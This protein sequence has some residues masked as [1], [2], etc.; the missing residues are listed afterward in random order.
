MPDKSD[1]AIDLLR[2]MTFILIPD[3][4]QTA[5]IVC[6]LLGISIN[7]SRETLFKKMLFV[8]YKTIYLYYNIIEIKKNGE[9]FL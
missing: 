3:K 4:N 8:L 6:F 2:F 5:K 7:V 9:G 1:S